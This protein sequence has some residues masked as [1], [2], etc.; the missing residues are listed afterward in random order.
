MA[1][2]HRFLEEPYKFLK[3]VVQDFQK[4]NGTIVAAAIA[5]YIFISLIPL[6]LLGVSI[7]GFFL[8]S[9]DQAQMIVFGFLEKYSPTL[10]EKG[11]AAGIG[12]VIEDIVKGRGTIGGIGLV[13]L[14]WAGSSA[15]A[16]LEKAVN[17]AWNSSIHRGFIKTRLL[18]I[19]M[20]LAV[21]V[22]LLIS[23]GLST[24]V[25]IVQNYDVTVFG[26]S[27]NGIPFIWAFLAYVIPL[28][29]IIAIFTIMYKVMP[30]IGV[31]WNPALLSGLVGTIF[32]EVARNGFSWYIG[33]FANFSA[34]YGSLAGLLILVFWIYYS[35]LILILAAEVGAASRKYTEL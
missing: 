28:A 7:L 29:A 32:W 12:T 33:N 11:G 6:L 9:P 10:L 2:L 13:G 20:L 15:F 31:A 19:I 4:D 18:A 25:N 23:L 34:V 24:L 21:G 8:G 14:L 30:N 22:L 26:I 35:S 16:N 3:L 1:K 5:F 27:P 17:I